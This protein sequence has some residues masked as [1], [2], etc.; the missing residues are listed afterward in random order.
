MKMK[1]SYIV[2]VLFSL[3][4]SFAFF[5][6]K[7][8]TVKFI[9]PKGW[10]DPVYDFSKNPL[11]EEGFKLG[12][13]LFYDPILSKDNTISCASCH[14][15]FTAFT[16]AD[17]SLSHG[18]YGKI[19][20]RN[21]SALMNLAWSK[22]FMWD[23]GVNN[24]EVQPINPLTNPLE[25]DSKLPDVVMELN[26]SAK[27]RKLFYK[28]FND[29]VI[30]SQ[31]LL[32]ALAQFTCRLNSSDSKYDSIMRHEKNVAFT[33]SEKNGYAL[34]KKNCSSC[35]TEPLFTNYSFQNNGLPVDTF[36]KDYG[37]IKITRNANDSLKF[38]VPTLRN[39]E[40]SAPYFHDGRVNKLK[41]V[42]EHYSNGVV[43]SATLAEELKSKIELTKQEK[44]DVIAF[45]KTLTD[46][47]FLYNGRFRYNFSETAKD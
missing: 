21:S 15:P 22:S 1:K 39:I 30:T 25:M 42:M 32:K 5:S 33:A 12:S 23:G 11:T 27:Y 36:L 35:H 34:F 31:L 28:T 41:D 18:I 29:S 26:Q 3:C 17:H 46:K 16:H 20:T 40:F 43:Q 8:K 7:T 9:V 2:F 38:R 37:R 4:V 19:G 14:L 6:P 45:L 47:Y 13:A 10:P 24:L 44:K